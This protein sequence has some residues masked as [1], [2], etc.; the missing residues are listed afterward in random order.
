MT[1]NDKTVKGCEELSPFTE[2]PRATL[3]SETLGG[4]KTLTRGFSGDL[5]LLFVVPQSYAP[6]A[7][8]RFPCGR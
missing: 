8:G 5:F 1:V 6:A 3:F 7:S 4:R 2:L